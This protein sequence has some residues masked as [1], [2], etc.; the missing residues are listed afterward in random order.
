MSGLRLVV[1]CE[2]DAYLAPEKTNGESGDT[3]EAEADDPGEALT[4][5]LASLSLSSSSSSSPT[6]SAPANPI[7]SQKHGLTVIKA[8][9]EV[10]QAS[11]TKIKSR[12]EQSMA[13]LR[14]YEVY[15]QLLLGQT[16]HA[17]IGVHL[18]GEFLKVQHVELGSPELEEVARSV[19]PGLRKLRYLLEEIQNAVMERGKDV[20][21]SLVCRQGMLVLLKRTSSNSLLPSEVLER[22][23]A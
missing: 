7:T 6:S 8:G 21:L 20:K 5:A 12:S 19:Q 11:L 4:S 18:K 9:T 16:F 17:M 14:W 2:V 1:R 3:S 13:S 10:P 23:E 22:F 15:P